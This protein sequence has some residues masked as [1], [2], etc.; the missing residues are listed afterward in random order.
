MLE[1]WASSLMGVDAESDIQALLKH[2]GP[3]DA[4]MEELN[5]SDAIDRCSSLW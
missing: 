5:A 2:I 1:A 4:Q 3:S